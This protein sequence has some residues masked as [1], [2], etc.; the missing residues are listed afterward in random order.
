MT[1]AIVSFKC[2]VSW[3]RFALNP[4][5]TKHFLQISPFRL[6][7]VFAGFLAGNRGITALFNYDH[8]L[9][10]FVYVGLGAGW[11]QHCFLLSKVC[12]VVL[13]CEFKQVKKLRLK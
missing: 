9:S 8:K 2:I 6:P 11:V 10:Q 1:K 3:L 13:I 7:F 12:P 5:E 4:H